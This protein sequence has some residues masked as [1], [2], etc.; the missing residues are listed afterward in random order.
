MAGQEQEPNSAPI[1]EHSLSGIR[2]LVLTDPET[3]ALCEMGDPSC[4]CGNLPHTPPDTP[5]NPPRYLSRPVL[6]VTS[7]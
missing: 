1:A 3:V 4:P 5:P 6:P 7:L 2:D